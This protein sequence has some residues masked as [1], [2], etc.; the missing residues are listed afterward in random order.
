MDKSGRINP[1]LTKKQ[2]E[3]ILKK[4]AQPMSEWKHVPKETETSVAH[5]SDGYSDKRKS[6]GKTVDKEG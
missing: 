3:A 6:Q 1:I 4:A 5:P 2:F